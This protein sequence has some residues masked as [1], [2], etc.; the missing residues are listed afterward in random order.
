MTTTK[1]ISDEATKH[2]CEI[3]PATEPSDVEYYQNLIN[4]K[5]YTLG[6]ITQFC[7]VNTELPINGFIVYL[8]ES[9]IRANDPYFDPD[10]DVTGKSILQVEYLYDVWV[11]EWSLVVESNTHTWY[12]QFQWQASHD[13]K[14]WVDIGPVMATEQIKITSM[15]NAENDA[16]WVFRNPEHAKQTKYKYW[17][18]MGKRGKTVNG[19]INLLLMNIE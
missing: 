12:A 15:M 11:T 17:R 19:F 4:T 7:R 14:A 9:S 8:L 1:R 10:V 13:K 18:A 16:E 2:F 3:Q 6:N 5:R